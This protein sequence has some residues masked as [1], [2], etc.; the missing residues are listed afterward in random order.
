MKLPRRGALV[1]PDGRVVWAW[2]EPDP[3]REFASLPPLISNFETGETTSVAGPDDVVVDLEMVLD[4]NDMSDLYHNMQGAR[5]KRQEDN[6]WRIRQVQ[7]RRRPDP[8]DP[9]Q[10]IEEEVENDHPLQQRIELRRGAL[11]EGTQVIGSQKKPKEERERT[12]KHS[13]I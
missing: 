5:L 2:D 7:T 10:E 3:D 11:P 12:P 4:S 6:S 8:D 9:A 1:K 13:V